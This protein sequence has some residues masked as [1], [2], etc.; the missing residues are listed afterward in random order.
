MIFPYEMNVGVTYKLVSV[1]LLM[2][3]LNR[4][5][6]EFDIDT[7]LFLKPINPNYIQA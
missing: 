6:S 2:V 7:Y 4:E 5:I 1:K 3:D